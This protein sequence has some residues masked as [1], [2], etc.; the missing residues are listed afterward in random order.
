MLRFCLTRL[1][2]LSLCLLPGG[3]LAS[4]ELLIASA[5]NFNHALEVLIPAFEKRTLHSVKSSLGSS[6]KLY[7]QIRH[8]APF[9]IFLS[10]DSLRPAKLEE[11]DNA[12]TGS[13][14]T[15]ALGRLAL[16]SPSNREIANEAEY[17][18][19]RPE[20]RLAMANPK[21]A[22]YGLAAEEVIAALS[23][24]EHFKGRIVAGES[25]AQ[26][27]QFAWSGNADAGFVAYSQV[28][29]WQRDEPNNNAHVWLVPASMHSPIEQQAVLLKHGETNP[30][31]REWMRFITSKEARDIITRFGYDVPSYSV[32]IPISDKR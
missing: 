26:A 19:S 11:L 1:M 27:F 15:Y 7:A 5:S 9:D 31:A 16:F 24:T 18:L 20:I 8:G 4:E 29:A 23:L 28:L 3:K 6:G 12:V 13:R 32:T 10:A 17:L 25:V 2:T 30:A 21:L 14:F 22:P